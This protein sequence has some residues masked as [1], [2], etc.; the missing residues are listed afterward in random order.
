MKR[1][2]ELL[3]AAVGLLLLAPLFLVVAVAISSTSRGP[4][5]FRQRRVGRFG[6]RFDIFKFRTM[7]QHSSRGKLITVGGDAR[8]TGVGRLLRRTKLDELPQLINVLRGEMSLVGPRPEVPE[9]VEL[10]LD[11]FAPILA[12]RPGITHRASIVFRDEEA[13]LARADDPERCYVERI[14]PHKLRLYREHMDRD[15]MADDVRTIVETVLRVARG[16]RQAPVAPQAIPVVRSE[17]RPGATAARA[18]QQPE[19]VEAVHS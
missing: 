18:R 12:V 1:P 13:M 9:Y 14:M 4:V 19:A 5:F 10:F 6:R 8:I 15:G 3:V 11:E 2:L 17:A 16:V 7:V